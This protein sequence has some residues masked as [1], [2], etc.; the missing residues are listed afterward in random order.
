ME[1]SRKIHRR[2]RRMLTFNRKEV[3]RQ[4]AL[5]LG[6]SETLFTDVMEF[7]AAV[8]KALVAKRRKDER[9]RKRSC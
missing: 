7:Y 3:L 9:P 8:T 4:A 1:K 5:I 6:N 2:E